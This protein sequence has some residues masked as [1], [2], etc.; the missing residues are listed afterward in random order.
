MKITR[1]KFYP[2]WGRYCYSRTGWQTHVCK[3]L[4][5]MGLRDFEIERLHALYFDSGVGPH[6][7]N[8]GFL[9]N[10]PKHKLHHLSRSFF[11]YDRKQPMFDLIERSGLFW[12]WKD[13]DAIRAVASPYTMAVHN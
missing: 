4:Q 1:P 9:R 11:H 5:S 10:L 13:G 7:D 8:L 3:R 6:H 2:H 12:V